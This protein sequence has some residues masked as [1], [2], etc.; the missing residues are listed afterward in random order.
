MPLPPLSL[1]DQ[2]GYTR[3]LAEFRGSFVVLYFYPK[4]FTSGCTTEACDFRDA[5][6]ELDGLGAIVLGV[7]KDSS[8]SHAKFDAKHT[9]GFALLSD[10]DLAATKAFAAFGTKTLH[11]KVVEGVKRKTV[12][13]S[14]DGDIIQEWSNVKVAGHVQ[15]VVEAI[16]AWRNE[17]RATHDPVV[18]KEPGTKAERT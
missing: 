12:L 13:L 1:S 16:R 10:P 14:P 18:A 4:D 9:L 2:G 5:S 17:A 15:H 6:K 8:S 7:S 3:T 11:G